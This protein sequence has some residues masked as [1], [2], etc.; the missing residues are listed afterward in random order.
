MLENET[1]AKLPG[2]LWVD[3]IDIEHHE[4]ALGNVWFAFGSEH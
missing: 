2:C 3:I 4:L 1:V